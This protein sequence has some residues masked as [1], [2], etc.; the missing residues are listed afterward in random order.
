MKWG[1]DLS[2]GIR[3]GDGDTGEAVDCADERG[4]EKQGE[5]LHAFFQIED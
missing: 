3:A 2:P 1:N 4:Q 5:V